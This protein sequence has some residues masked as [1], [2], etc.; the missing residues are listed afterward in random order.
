MKIPLKNKK[1][2]GIFVEGLFLLKITLLSRIN[3]GVRHV[4]DETIKH[5]F[6]KCNFACS[7]WSVIQVASGLYPPTSIANVFGNWVHGIDYKFRILLRVG[8]MTL[9]WL[10]WLCRNDKV[11]YNKNSSLLQVIYRCTDTFRL[12]SKLHRTE[13]HDLFSEVCT[14]LEDNVRDLFLRHG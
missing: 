8:A 9:I 7:I 13:D 4:H 12:W 1:L 14:R 3:M 2:H 11:F 10:L 5:L 6:L